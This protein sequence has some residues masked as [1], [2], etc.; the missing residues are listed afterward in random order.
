MDKLESKNKTTVYSCSGCSNVAQLANRVAVT[1][2]REKIATMSCIA[3]V[4]GNVPALVNLAKKAKNILVID[5]CSLTCAFHC[6]KNHDIIPNDHITLTD[7]ELSKNMHSDIN[8]DEFRRIYKKINELILKYDL[9]H[10]ER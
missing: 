3:G 1:L 7:M 8:D 10:I 9:N 4:G 5:G 6:L 2:D